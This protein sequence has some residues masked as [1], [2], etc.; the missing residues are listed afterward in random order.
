MKNSPRFLLRQNSQVVL[1]GQVVFSWHPSNPDSSVALPDGEAWFITPE[2][3]F[4]LLQ[5]PLAASFT[6]LQP[7]LG[8]AHGDL[9][10][11]WGCSAMETHFMKLQTNSYCADVAS[12]GSLEL[13]GECYRL[14]LCASTL[15]GH[16]LWACAVYPFEA[17]QGIIW[18]NWHVGK[19]ASYDGAT[20]KVTPQ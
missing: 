14:F 18:T 17:R 10:L 12:R 16:V 5:S 19:V 2:N 6:P 15:S 7:T 1:F 9:R 20:L 13:G 3:A 4:P 8:V 11:M